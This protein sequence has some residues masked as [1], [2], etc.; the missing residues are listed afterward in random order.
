MCVCVC[1]CVCVCA[2][3]YACV[4]LWS[5]CAR[6]CTLGCRSTHVRA[7]TPAQ[8]HLPVCERVHTQLLFVVVSYL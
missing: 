4:F 2:C 3:A 5:A 7:R 6:A 1:V 8:R